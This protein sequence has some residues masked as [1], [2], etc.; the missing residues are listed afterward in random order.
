M[1]APYLNQ[2]LG[3]RQLH[4]RIHFIPIYNEA[5][6][7]PRNRKE[8]TQFAAK[9]GPTKTPKAQDKTKQALETAVEEQLQ[10]AQNPCS[11]VCCSRTA[12]LRLTSISFTLVHCRFTNSA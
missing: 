9:I 1:I 2:C 5:A 11:F 12:H 4:V 3:H 6:M 8:F 10:R 7:H